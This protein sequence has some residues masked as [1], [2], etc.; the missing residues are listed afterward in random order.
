MPECRCVLRHRGQSADCLPNQT[1][2]QYHGAGY[3]D[4]D[5]GLFKNF[6]FKERTNLAVGLM[7]FNAFNHPNMPFPNNSFST[8]DSTFGT[9]V[10]GPAIGV[11]TSPYGNFLGFD[12]SPRIVQLS[13]KIT[14]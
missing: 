2:N 9:I 11:P 6:K 10:S 5:M 8:G 1:R 12:S 4:M 14:F 13:A 3:F 7:A